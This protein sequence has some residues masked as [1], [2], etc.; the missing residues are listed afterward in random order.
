MR[1]I[2]DYRLNYL[3]DLFLSKLILIFIWTETRVHK[4]VYKS[5]YFNYRLN[6]NNLYVEYF[7][8]IVLALINIFIYSFIFLLIFLR[9]SSQALDMNF[10]ACLPKL[11]STQN[12]CRFY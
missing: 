2:S 5:T 7:D 6:Y 9:I 10:S 12:L 11:Y 3:E 4:R 1:L 8:T